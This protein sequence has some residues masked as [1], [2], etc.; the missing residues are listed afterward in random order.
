LLGEIDKE[1]ILRSSYLGKQRITR[2][3]GQRP[4]INRRCNGRN[5]YQV[6]RL[7]IKVLVQ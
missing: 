1:C 4:T 5:I 3:T 6:L 2:R 7:F